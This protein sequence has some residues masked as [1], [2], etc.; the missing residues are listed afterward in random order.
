VDKT[1]SYKIIKF[2][3]ISWKIIKPEYNKI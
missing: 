3:M 2:I 1:E